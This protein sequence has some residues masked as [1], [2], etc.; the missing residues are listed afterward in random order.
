MSSISGM[1]RD[2]IVLFP[3][4]IDDDISQENSV[5]FI[6][7]FVEEINL[8]KQGFKKSIPAKTGRPAYDPRAL[9]KLYILRIQK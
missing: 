4:A 6:D 8:S 2:Q 7:A 5:R 3:E 9:L 1:S